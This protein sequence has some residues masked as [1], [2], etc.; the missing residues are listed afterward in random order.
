METGSTNASSFSPYTVA[1]SNDE[2]S[3]SDIATIEYRTSGASVDR[4]NNLRISRFAAVQGALQTMCRLPKDHDFHIDPA[5]A[6]K[7]SDL[8]GLISENYD[9]SPPKVIPQ[10]GEAVVFTWDFGELKRYLTVDEEEI[11]VMDLHKTRRIRCVH[12]I[13]I[14]GDHPYA[15]L[16]QMIGVKSTST[17]LMD[18]DADW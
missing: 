13:A 15:A 8:L 11:D 6:S 3:T 4:S 16:A 10:D 5:T 9:V 12:E 18:N 1:G 14:E 2:A 17:T 7:A